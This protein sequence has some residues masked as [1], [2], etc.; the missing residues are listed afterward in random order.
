MLPSHLP[1]LFALLV[2]AAPA[3]PAPEPPS[4]EQAAAAAAAAKA[5]SDF[6]GL[7]LFSPMDPFEYTRSALF[8]PPLLLPKGDWAFAVQLDYASA[9][10][11][12]NDLP[13][14]VLLDAEIGHLTFTGTFKVAPSV[15]LFLSWGVQGAYAGFMDGFLNAYH[16]IFDITYEARTL[17][18][19]NKFAYYFQ[20]GDKRQSFKP[21]GLTLLDTQLGVG[22]AISEQLQL[23][24]V[25]VVPTAWADGYAAHTAQ[26][27]AILTFQ[28]PFIWP[29]LLFQGTVGLG[30]TPRAGGGLLQQ[31]QNVVFGSFS[32]GF[33]ARLTQRNF[34]Y[35]NFFLQTPLYR[36]TGDWPLDYVDGSL[37]FGWMFRTDANWEFILGITEN[38]V[39]NGPAPDVV[40]RFGFRHGF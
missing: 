16:S 10:N 28:R 27:A 23:L 1:F 20:S 4:A 34:L 17:R 3:E 29:W 11:L 38:P 22:W 36:N 24:T 19:L 40:F 15:F 30:A 35:C 7:P 33:K 13:N 18:P 9:I 2:T 12:F 14:S 5:W 37:D 26:F 32:V 39:A 25:L 21:Q 8:A 6:P 31:Y